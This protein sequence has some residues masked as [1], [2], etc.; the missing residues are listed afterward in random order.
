MSDSDARNNQGGETQVVGAADAAKAEG[1]DPAGPEAPTEAREDLAA[2]FKALAE[3]SVA[4]DRALVACKNMLDVAAIEGQAPELAEKALGW[5]RR[6]EALE[7]QLG[8]ILDSMKA[9]KELL[10]EAKALKAEVDKVRNEHVNTIALARDLGRWLG[11]AQ[12][13]EVGAAQAMAELIA[14]CKI[15]SGEA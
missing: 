5:S 14:R 7:T 15:I 4:V 11:M 6:V 8:I 10:V 3:L 9:A 13:E 2:Q 1:S 12:R